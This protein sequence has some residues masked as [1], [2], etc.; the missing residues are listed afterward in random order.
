MFGG[1]SVKYSF[2]LCLIHVSKE[3]MKI[4]MEYEIIKN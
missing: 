3:I 2:L 1:S 4:F